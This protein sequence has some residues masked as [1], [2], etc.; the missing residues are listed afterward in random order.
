MCREPANQLLV[1]AVK[2]AEVTMIGCLVVAQ[3]E[4]VKLREGPPW[5]GRSRLRSLALSVTLVQLPS[6]GTKS[7]VGVQPMK[8]GL[9]LLV[10]STGIKMLGEGEW[11]TKNMEPMTF[12]TGVR[13][14]LPL[15]L[16]RWKSGPLM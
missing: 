2:G 10:D 8:M 14:I 7:V 3:V 16:P 5:F 11:K 4:L 12:A 6:W 15:T 9:H 1:Y 13:S